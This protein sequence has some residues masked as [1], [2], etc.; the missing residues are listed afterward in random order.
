[1]L[2]FRDE[3]HDAIS[4]HNKVITSKGRV[5][6]GLWLKSFEDKADIEKKLQGFG[7]QAIYIADTTS[8]SKPAIHICEAVRVVT[9]TG[10]VE[11]AH[12]P[13]YYRKKVKEVPIWFELVSRINRIDA[14]QSLE[15]LIGVPTIY[16]LEYD[17]GGNV[18]NSAP[19][20]DFSFSAGESTLILHISDIHLGDDHAFRYP[21]QY[22]KSD[23]SSAR[24]LSE[25]MLDDLADIG[26]LGKIG[27]VVVSGDIVTRGAWAKQSEIEGQCLSG[28]E[29]ARLVLEDLS[30][31][32]GV[33]G[34]RFFMVPGNHDIVRQSDGQAE[35]NQEYLLHYNHEIGFRTLR[36]DF[37]GIYKLSPLNYIARV[38]FKG[39]TLVLGLLNSAYLNEKAKFSEY[40]FVGDDADKVFSALASTNAADVVKILVLHHHLLPVYER[41]W[42]GV[43]GKIS[44][45]LDAA[46]LLSQAQESDVCTVLHGHE[47]AIKKMQ[48]SSWA[49]TMPSSLQRMNRAVMLYAGGSVRVKSSR[50]PPDE[51]NA[52]GVIDIS[53][54]HPTVRIR[55]IFSHGRRG[56]DWEPGP[57]LV[58]SA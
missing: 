40:G 6:W 9:D 19:Q 12:V 7:K 33:P 26:A 16:F 22:A 56:E 15:N 47:H 48:Y 38:K 45:T 20:R 25:V 14:A 31:K 1:M 35:A 53:G 23:T 34:D 42:L 28:L 30:K 8:K 32:L 55:R 46:R 18:V 49:P 51:S 11:H 41:E 13:K 36:E 17:K 4:E 57:P 52:Y 29:L 39:R 54:K 43:D 58:S 37:C 5:F 27:C 21:L 10:L 3:L 50:R 2:R 44:L 24:T